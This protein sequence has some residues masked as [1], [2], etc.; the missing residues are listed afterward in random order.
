MISESVGVVKKSH[1]YIHICNYYSYYFRI[2][3]LTIDCFSFFFSFSLLKL[4]QL[5]CR[6]R[7]RCPENESLKQ[8]DLFRAY[9]PIVKRR[10]E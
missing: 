5:Y 10:N 8:R 1:S 4:K 3:R 6:N 2:I 9:L 7:C